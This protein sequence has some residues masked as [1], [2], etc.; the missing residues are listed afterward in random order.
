VSGSDAAGRDALI[1]AKSETQ[2]RLRWA[3]R[4]LESTRAA[5]E[6]AG[7]LRRRFLRRRLASLE[8][9]VD[10]LMSQEMRLRIEIDRTAR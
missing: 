3:Q 2:A 7:G 9:E 5:L 8:S 4:D 1:A 10:C 6:T